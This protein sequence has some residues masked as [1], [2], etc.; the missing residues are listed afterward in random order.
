MQVGGRL[1]GQEEQCEQLI[2][3]LLDAQGQP[4]Q[5]VSVFGPPGAGEAGE[6]ESKAG[7]Q[8]AAYPSEQ[9]EQAP[10]S[11]SCHVSPWATDCR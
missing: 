8:P 11:P 2:E 5:V 10:V 1:Q 4:P 3:V 7:A 9:P 6:G